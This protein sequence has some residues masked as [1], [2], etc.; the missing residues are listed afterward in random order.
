MENKLNPCDLL[1]IGTPVRVR[2][3]RGKVTSAEM[4]PAVPSG[5]I[6]VHTVRLEEKLSTFGAGRSRWQAIKPKTQNCNYSFIS[7]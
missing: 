2:N 4:R 6:A 1:P 7:Y 5:F 3:L